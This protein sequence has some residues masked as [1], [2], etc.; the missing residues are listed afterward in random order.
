MLLERFMSDGGEIP[1]LVDSG[2]ENGKPE[3]TQKNRKAF[4]FSTWLQLERETK[5]MQSQNKNTQTYGPNERNE[6]TY[7]IPRI[8]TKM[9]EEKLKK[10][11]KYNWRKQGWKMPEI[12][13]I[14]M[15]EINDNDQFYQAFVYHEPADLVLNRLAGGGDMWRTPAAANGTIQEREEAGE[16]IKHWFK[17]G[18]RDRFLLILPNRTPMTKLAKIMA[19]ML[20]DIGERVMDNLE[21]LASNGIAEIPFALPSV[22]DARFE[23]AEL[24]ENEIETKFADKLERCAESLCQLR[25]YCNKN[26]I[27]HDQDYEKIDEMMEEEEQIYAGLEEEERSIAATKAVERLIWAQHGVCI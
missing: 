9:D 4:A 6:I 5:A 20:A 12:A 7:V 14:D 23:T 26:G 11:L 24:G 1:R 10:T 27:S 3:K 8:P 16:P 22:E 19:D 2:C 21:A 13:R 15:V 17:A 25:A 18:H